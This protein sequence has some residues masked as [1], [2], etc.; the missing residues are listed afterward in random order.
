MSEERRKLW[1]YLYPDEPH[2]QAAIEAIETIPQRQRS[3]YFRDSLVAGIAL[4]KMDKRLPTL[5]ALLLDEGS[6]IKTLK[7]VLRLVSP[8]FET[9]G[10]IEGNTLIAVA[11]QKRIKDILQQNQP[12][13]AWFAIGK[14]EY[15]R[16]IQTPESDVQVRALYAAKNGDT[17]IDETGKIQPVNKQNTPV[18]K[19]SET[20]NNAKKM[21]GVKKE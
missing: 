5:L 14:E 17:T 16:L 21:F 10:D 15:D 19:E 20:L 6:D 7:R 8:E 1:L 2:Q 3:D 9:S 4:S 13:T 11:W 12:W 18:K